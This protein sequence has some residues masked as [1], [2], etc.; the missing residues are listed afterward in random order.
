MLLQLIVVECTCFKNLENKLQYY[1]MKIIHRVN[2][3][4]Q[5]PT[6]YLHFDDYAAEC[7]DFYLIQGG[8]VKHTQWDEYGLSDEELK[9]IKTKKIIHLEFEEPNKY[10]VG[11]Y[12]ELYDK[13][14]FKIFTICPYTAD[15]LNKKY[16]TSKRVPIF[17][18]VH[19]KYIPKKTTKTID[20]IYSGH[21]ISKEL[22]GELLQL[23]KFNY[24]VI[25]NSDHPIVNYRSVSY[26]EKMKLYAKSKITLVHNIMYKPY[27]HRIVNVWLS[28]S[29]RENQAFKQI[30]PPW[31]FWEVFTKQ[32]YIPQ[33]KSRV[34]EAAMTKSLILCRRDDFNVIENYFVPDKEFVYYEP[35]K[36]Q[37]SIQHILANYSKYE[38]IAERAYNRAIKEYTVKAFVN[39]YLKRI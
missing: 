5:C 37:E 18:P 35:G 30:P 10:F 17:F 2:G 7:G 22:L 25:S 28:P 21:I 38:R 24:A 39:K 14:F 31:R 9:R 4:A 32:I 16:Q 8:F 29:F 6:R 36:L 27:F 33:L 3:Y 34:F 20:V 13:Q 11:D 12:P 15:A 23:Q 19:E 1:F 26:E